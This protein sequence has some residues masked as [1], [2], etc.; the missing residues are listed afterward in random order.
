M[1]M[2]LLYT[3][4]GVPRTYDEFV[5]K[6]MKKGMPVNVRLELYDEMSDANSLGLSHYDC[7]VKL[8][9]ENSSLEMTKFSFMR[10]SN[11]HYV[12]I[13]KAQT[14]VCA[15]K[16][17]IALSERLQSAGIE[18]SIGTDRHSIEK[19]RTEIQNLEDH[20]SKKRK[21]FSFYD[22]TEIK[23]TPVRTFL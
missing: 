15:M 19:S 16:E 8:Q 13:G 6:V 9:A 22:E 1:S 11:L 23:R 20:I 2:S 21:E 7:S 17:A 3:L 14:Q 4:A 18:V 12:V 10:N 5:D